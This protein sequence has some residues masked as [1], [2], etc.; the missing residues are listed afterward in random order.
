MLHG[1]V[2]VAHSGDVQREFVTGAILEGSVELGVV[3]LR[4]F[5]G[6]G[7]SAVQFRVAQHAL[8]LIFEG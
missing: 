4:T 2:V 1:G 3:L 8:A 6:Y 5:A 7:F